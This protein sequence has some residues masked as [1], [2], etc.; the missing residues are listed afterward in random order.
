MTPGWCFHSLT[1]SGCAKKRRSSRLL[2]GLTSSRGLKFIFSSFW[3]NQI[4]LVSV[5]LI[6]PLSSLPTSCKYLEGSNWILGYFGGSHSEFGWDYGQVQTYLELQLFHL[7]VAP[8]FCVVVGR[9][10]PQFDHDCG[11]CFVRQ[12]SSHHRIS[13]HG[14][15][16]GNLS[17]LRLCFLN[18]LTHKSLGSWYPYIYHLWHSHRQPL[19]LWMT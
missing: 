17:S 8:Q 18:V 14:Q 6:P 1:A 5:H 7:A 12:L 19:A 2:W 10:M 4:Q 15:T 11:C 16:S 13:L 9:T 3:S